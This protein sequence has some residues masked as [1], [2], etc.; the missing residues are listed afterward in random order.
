MS[1]A[2]GGRRPSWMGRLRARAAAK[3]SNGIRMQSQQP[4][5]TDG[6][7]PPEEVLD[8]QLHQV[9]RHHEDGRRRPLLGL[10]ALQTCSKIRLADMKAANTLQQS[11]AMQCS[12]YR[13]FAAACVS[14]RLP[15]SAALCDREGSVLLLLFTS[16]LGT[17]LNAWKP[18]WR[19]MRC[20]TCVPLGSHRELVP[21]TREG[22]TMEL[23]AGQN[24]AP[25]LRR[26]GRV[27]Q[28]LST[29][30]MH[31]IPPYHVYGRLKPRRVGR[32]PKKGELAHHCVAGICRRS[33]RVLSVV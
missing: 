28:G 31:G 26:L 6:A 4:S 16:V 32:R 9:V 11:W 8:Q 14:A 13:V 20:T 2:I 30:S 33:S 23:A 19:P 21:S 17:M 15:G 3:D 18:K 1:T 29:S 5:P 25:A 22:H 27:R 10:R 24:S 7:L 12:Q